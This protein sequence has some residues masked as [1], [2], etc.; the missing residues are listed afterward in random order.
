M[1]VKTKNKPFPV[2]PEKENQE[3][4]PADSAEEIIVEEQEQSELIYGDDS[5]E[6]D[7]ENGKKVDYGFSEEFGDFDNELENRADLPLELKRYGNRYNP[8]VSSEP[9]VQEVDDLEKEGLNISDSD[10]IGMGYSDNDYAR[11]EEEEDEN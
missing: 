2:Q 5:I 10:E 1:Q 8:A 4:L 3:F 9:E 11:E 7:L 6:M